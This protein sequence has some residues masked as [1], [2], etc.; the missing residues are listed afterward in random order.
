MTVEKF[1]QVKKT[2]TGMSGLSPNMFV[3]TLNL[4]FG[5]FGDELNMTY[6]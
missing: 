4:S 6:P 5:S 2:G 1:I 3:H